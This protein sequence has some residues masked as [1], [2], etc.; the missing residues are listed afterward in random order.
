M[1]NWALDVTRGSDGDLLELYCGNGNFT[2]PLA[3]NFKQ[4]GGRNLSPCGMRDCS[5]NRGDGRARTRGGARKGM[6]RR[7]RKASRF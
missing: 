2:I 4:V 3:Q 5:R 1:L 7:G 6:G